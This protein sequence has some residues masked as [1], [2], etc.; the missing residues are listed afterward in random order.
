MRVSN[1]FIPQCRCG[2]VERP[3][4][5]TAAIT[6]PCSIRS[7]TFTSIRDRCRK[8]ELMPKP[9][10]STTVPPV[11]YRSGSAKL[12]TPAAGALTGVPLGA[13]M[14]MPEC[15]EPGLPL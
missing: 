3:V 6:W 2:P 4:E 12:T 15:A 1:Q 7:P 13:A 8:L 11:R 9:W 5:P 10:S 14:S